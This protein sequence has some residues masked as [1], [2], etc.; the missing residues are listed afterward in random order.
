MSIAGSRRVIRKTC[1]RVTWRS[2]LGGGKTL[3]RE[4][5]R[6]MGPSIAPG[7][8]SAIPLGRALSVCTAD[9]FASCVA[10]VC[11]M[12]GG[13]QKRHAFCGPFGRGR[14]APGF[15]DVLRYRE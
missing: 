2:V 1:A 4:S 13:A 6:G 7:M 11:G 9:E 5:D 3:C 12:L 15:C 14:C 8:P 10:I